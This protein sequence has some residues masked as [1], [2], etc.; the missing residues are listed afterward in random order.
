MFSLSRIPSPQKFHA[1][2]LTSAEKWFDHHI[3]SKQA[4]KG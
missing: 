1:F 2:L 3:K 4:D